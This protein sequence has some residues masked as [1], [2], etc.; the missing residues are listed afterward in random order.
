MVVELPML[1]LQHTDL[2]Q[3]QERQ[4]KVAIGVLALV[5]AQE[6]VRL[7]VDSL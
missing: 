3:R 6:A 2:I 4:E 5:E 1:E 7:L